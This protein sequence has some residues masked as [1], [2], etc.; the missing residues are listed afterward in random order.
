MP[1]RWNAVLWITAFQ[2]L[3]M[4]HHYGMIETDHVNDAIK[5]AIRAP[6]FGGDRVDCADQARML[7][8]LVEERNDVELERDCKQNTP[9]VITT[10]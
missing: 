1:R 3:G 2:R 7:R 6:D 10:A 4:P 8:N 5:R 9:K